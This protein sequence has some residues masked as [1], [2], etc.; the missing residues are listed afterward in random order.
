MTINGKLVV[1]AGPSAVGKGTLASFIVQNYPSFHLSV[2]STT[3][4]PRSGEI[5]GLSYFFLSQEEFSKQVEAGQ[6]LEWATV[7]GKHSYG[8]P[9]S[10]VE[11]A[12]ASGQ[13]VL[14]E[15]DVQGAFQVK[16]AL[17]EALLVFVSP[18][19][20]DD[21]KDRLDKR[22]TESELDKAIR[23]ETAKQ[24]IAEATKF[25]FQVIND[26]V[27]RCAHEVVELSQAT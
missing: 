14:L 12:L 27:A 19:H 5:H 16:K 2:S 4:A 25:D 20:F 1:I 15:I 7:H 3:R 9:R 26:D 22:G 21:L 6:M 10:P 23:L 18:P 24:E 13:N 17:P 11:K 8:T